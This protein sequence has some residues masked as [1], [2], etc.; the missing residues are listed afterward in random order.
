MDVETVPDRAEQAAEIALDELLSSMNISTSANAYQ[1]ALRFLPQNFEQ[2]GLKFDCTLGT[3]GDQFMAALQNG[4]QFLK[5][6]DLRFSIGYCDKLNESVLSMVAEKCRFTLIDLKVCC[7]SD[8][9]I[10]HPIPSVLNLTYYDTPYKMNNS[11]PD[12]NQYFPNVERFEMKNIKGF[13]ERFIEQVPN[14]KHFSY[15][16]PPMYAPDSS[17]WQR[18][19]QFLNLNPQLESL[20]LDLFDD[21]Q[22][23]KQLQATVHW[24]ALK[25][26]QLKLTA[27]TLHLE[28]ILRLKHLK[29]VAIS[30]SQYKLNYN[31][32]KNGN[33][34]IEELEI[35]IFFKD[36]TIL[37]FI[38]N[39]R[40]LKKLKLNLY[41]AL[42][43]SYLKQLINYLQN[44][45]E[46][47]F[48]VFVQV[49]DDEREVADGIFDFMGNCKKLQTVNVF[50]AINFSSVEVDKC[51]KYVKL[52]QEIEAQNK[53]KLNNEIW[54]MAYELK[55]NA[56]CLPHFHISFN[57]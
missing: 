24:N 36:Y 20:S 1:N 6:M 4:G 35:E 45:T 8:V 54:R 34:S 33:T 17:D 19:A 10:R 31:A 11:W 23:Q 56:L 22:L 26:R 30:A 9:I 57:K 38:A 48:H 53:W 50:Y 27:D 16:S 51:R 37:N 55:Q 49:Y 52:Y 39:C 42:E 32:L 46:I 2:N 40:N 44:L 15:S 25:I 43:F 7:I 3:G 29:S 18:I 47:S 21:G 41:A 14:L 12:L 13:V 28:Y 5:K